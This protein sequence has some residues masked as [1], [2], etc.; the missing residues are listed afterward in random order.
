MTNLQRLFQLKQAPSQSISD[1]E[2]SRIRD[3]NLRRGQK[4]DDSILITALMSATR[5]D[6]LRQEIQ[7]MCADKSVKYTW[8][9]ICEKA[10]EFDETR[11]ALDQARRSREPLHRPHHR[12]SRTLDDSTRALALTGPTPTPS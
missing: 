5:S 9:T 2:I 3:D 10:R 1:T 12:P 4:I 8:H 6:R 7:I 11:L